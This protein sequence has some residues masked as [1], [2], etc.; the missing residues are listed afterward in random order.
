MTLPRT[1]VPNEAEAA[2]RRAPRVKVAEPR[3]MVGRRPSR[4]FIGPEASEPKCPVCGNPRWPDAGQRRTLVQ[5]RR[6]ESVSDA[7]TS[8]TDD[9]REERFRRPYLTT[10]LFEPGPKEGRAARMIDGMAFGW[11]LHPRGTLRE[12][13]LGFRSGE[14]NRVK[15]GG[16]EYPEIGFVTCKSCGAVQNPYAR[17]KQ[18]LAAKDA[19]DGAAME[20][21]SKPGSDG[22]LHGPGCG[23]RSGK[24]LEAVSLYLYREITSEALRI[25]LPTLTVTQDETIASFKAALQL[26]LRRYFSGHPDHLGM[27]TISEPTRGSD[28]AKRHYLLLYDMVPGG[29]G[30]LAELFRDDTLIE[31]L[32]LAQRAILACRCQEKPLREPFGQEITREGCYR[33]LYAYQAQ[34]DIPHISREI[35]LGQLRE[36]LDAEKTLVDVVSVSDIPTDTRLESELEARFV[37]GLRE[38]CEGD[39]TAQFRDGLWHKGEPSH[40]IELHGARWR[41]E[42]QVKIGSKDGV[43]LATQPDF[44]FWPEDE[45]MGRPVAVYCDGFAYH[46]CPDDAQARIWDDIRKREALVESGK[47]VVWSVTWKDVESFRHDAQI[48]NAPSLFSKVEA[49]WAYAWSKGLKDERLHL[50]STMTGLVKYLAQPIPQ[51]WEGLSRGLA[52]ALMQPGQRWDTEEREVLRDQLTR[53]RTRGDVDFKKTDEPTTQELAGRYHPSP[54]LDALVTMPS[55]EKLKPDKR[56]ER[57]E[58]VLRLF[59]EQFERNHEDF[60]A[61]W[62]RFWHAHNLLQF[63]RRVRLESS[64]RIARKPVEMALERAGEDVLSEPP[65]STEAAVEEDPD[66][67]LAMELA[68]DKHHEALRACRDEGLIYPEVGEVLMDGIRELGQV[69]LSWEDARVAVLWPGAAKH[70]AVKSA[71]KD[72]GWTVVAPPE[73]W[74]TFAGE[75]EL[76]RRDA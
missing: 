25:L 23:T 69:D 51:A 13:N 21:T 31:V 66:F 4:M 35:A 24:K 20:A 6:A 5:F 2:M 10:Q 28:T 63:H 33:C 75:H 43:E 49:K 42:P 64:E 73:D 71:L 8:V 27:A 26:G 59:D 68:D 54:F 61:A 1:S 62:R 12:L 32:R 16:R 47:F 7:V 39:E 18:A 9:A 60:E 17:R 58:V 72:N 46:A 67:E 37:L 45:G 65:P 44:V 70:D 11:E 19:E 14:G 48:T 3:R 41:L 40:E 36:L 74:S 76:P 30:Y 34:E 15:I 22:F 52:T 53:G 57:I 38:Y 55:S 50:Q 56:L 29:T